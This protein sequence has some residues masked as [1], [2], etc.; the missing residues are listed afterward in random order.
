MAPAD[1]P[2]AVMIS[3]PPEGVAAAKAEIDGLV[4]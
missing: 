1:R 4:Q 3:G 2:R